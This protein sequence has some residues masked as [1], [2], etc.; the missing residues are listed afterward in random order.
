MRA[1]IVALVTTVALFTTVMAQSRKVL[2]LPLDGNAP[3]AQKTA[4][5][6]TVVRLAKEKG[7]GDVTAGDTTFN[8]TAAAVGCDPE[9][10]ACAET[11]RTTIS[12][13]MLCPDHVNADSASGTRVNAPR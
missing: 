13:R 12:A 1:A 7:G 5:D 8:E 11:V 10:P 4:L 6:A 2:V 3:A 9:Q